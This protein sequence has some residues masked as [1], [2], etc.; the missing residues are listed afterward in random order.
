M[1]IRKTSVSAPVD[2]P[3][4]LMLEPFLLGSSCPV[5]IATEDDIPLCVTGMPA[6]AGTAIAE[7]MPGTTSKGTPFF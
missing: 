1:P 5:A 6:Y 3:F 7:V 4:Q 2:R